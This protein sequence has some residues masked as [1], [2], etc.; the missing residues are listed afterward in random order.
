MVILI[1]FIS[2]WAKGLTMA[3]II[4]SILEMILPNNKTKKYVR[5]IMG[6]FLLFTIISPFIQNDIKQE[7]SVANLED[8]FSNQTQI[9]SKD[10]INQTSMNERI[11]ELYIQEL[12]KDIKNKMNE[13]GY[14]IEKIKIDVNI[15]DEQSETKINKI[16]LK[17]QKMQESEETTTK[18]DS[19]EN[20]IVTQVE[21]IK[22]ID[23]SIKKNEE[24][25][26]NNSK[27]LSN[28]TSAD[29]QNIKNF[30]KEEYGV[31]EKCLEIN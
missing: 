8:L 24:K 22:E 29:L 4:I 18:N 1:E 13:K 11:E 23:T 21:K 14:E 17:L 20:K 31:D 19:L 10:E 2:N 3:V 16:K 12:E 15:A 27:E 5:M 6:V 7:L 9:E 25:N 28:L 26:Y 30:L